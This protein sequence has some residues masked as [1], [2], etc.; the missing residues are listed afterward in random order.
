VGEFDEVINKIVGRY[1][2]GKPQHE[3][4]D[5][6][7]DCELA[8]IEEAE[9]LSQ[10]DGSHK[11]KYAYRVCQSFLLHGFRKQI[12]TNSLSD[13]AVLAQAEK[14]T[15]EL[16]VDGFLDGKTAVQKMDILTET[17]RKVLEMR[18]GLNGF[19]EKTYE[20]IGEAFG[21]TK[22]WA[23]NTEKKALKKLRK[24]F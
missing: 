7:Q 3:K 10:L 15:E 8:L 22:Q 9:A 20:E 14:D 17:Q 6:K 23:H 18:F 11:T 2:R 1:S 21:F 5:F 24:E 4:E 19:S 13:E 16:D 12:K